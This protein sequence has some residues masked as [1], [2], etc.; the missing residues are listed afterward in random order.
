M[1]SVDIL[2]K[3]PSL[4]PVVIGV[5]PLPAFPNSTV[6]KQCLDLL[7]GRTAAG[8]DFEQLLPTQ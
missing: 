6:A 4:D 2:L 7:V 3:H 1:Y 5:D 8:D